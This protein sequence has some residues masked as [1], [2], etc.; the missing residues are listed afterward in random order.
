MTRTVFAGEPTEEAKKLYNLILKSQLRATKEI[1]EGTSCKL[2]A[3]NVENDFYL[4]NYSLIHAL[5]HGVGLDVHELPILSHNS[6]NIL[7]ENMIVTN[8]PG[9]YLQD[10]FGIRIEDTIRVGKLESEVLT[11]SNKELLIVG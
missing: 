11:K 4:Y 9:I 2:I 7:K 1:K 8:E 5:G 10:N 6:Q 3:R